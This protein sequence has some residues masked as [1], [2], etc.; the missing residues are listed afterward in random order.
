MKTIGF[1][2]PGLGISGGVHIVLR[3][4]EILARHGH[5]VYLL[6]PDAERFVQVPFLSPEQVRFTVLSYEDGARIPFDL[7]FGTWW[8]TLGV[9]PELDARAYAFFAQAL[10]SQFYLPNDFAQE[11]YEHLMGSGLPVVSIAHWLSEHFVR[12]FGVPAERVQTV[13]NPLD[14]SLWRPA[15]PM[16]PRGDR[17]R[18]L[19]E[20]PSTDARKNIGATV[21]LLEDAG[22]EYIWVGAVVD[23][24]LVGPR[25]VKVLERVP[26]E[27]MPEVYASCDVLV[28]LSNAEGMFGPPLEMFATGGTALVWDVAGAEEYMAHLHNCVMAPLNSQPAVY[29]AIRML[30]RDP[31]LV[32]RLKRN[33]LATAQAWPDWEQRVPDILAAVERIPQVD[34]REFFRRVTHYLRLRVIEREGGRKALPNG[35]WGRPAA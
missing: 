24:R 33:A 10:E 12:H 14:R 29:D 31:E 20:G 32:A 15:S 1:V 13:L 9:L 23:R 35:A 34:P 4:S 28:K 22:V 2:L 25:C 17:L 5:Q 27:R 26:Y 19:V 21:R 16:V 3:W 11:A 18:F 6:V 8:E 7:V 30:E